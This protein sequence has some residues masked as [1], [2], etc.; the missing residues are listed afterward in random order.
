MRSHSGP[1]IVV[2]GLIDMLGLDYQSEDSVTAPGTYDDPMY[3][4]SAVGRLLGF[5]P[6]IP[7]LCVHG[8][9]FHNAILTYS[10]IMVTL[11]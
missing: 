2:V 7:F 8:W 4:D 9:T 11:L 3:S 6:A 1:T 5:D 10:N